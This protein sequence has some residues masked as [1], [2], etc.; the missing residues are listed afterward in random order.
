M[1]WATVRRYGSRLLTALL[2]L[3]AVLVLAIAVNVIG[4]RIAGSIEG[5]ERWME[6]HAGFFLVW[7]LLLYGGTA[8]GWIWMRRRLRAREP[9]S[10]TAQR[11]LRLE[12]AAVVALLILE[13][14]LLMQPG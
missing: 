5:W 1:N 10:T 7:R 3:V 12:I 14:S 8:W 13:G 4:I 9:D 11:L 6:A 2:L